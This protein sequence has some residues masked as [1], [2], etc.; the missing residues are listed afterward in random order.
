MS[1]KKKSKQRKV[2]T[3]DKRKDPKQNN[4][5]I[6]SQTV[7]KSIFLILTVVVISI[8]GIF[9]IVD[10]DWPTSSTQEIGYVPKR[11]PIPIIPNYAPN[12]VKFENFVGS[13][14]CASC[15]IDIYTKW[16]SST[17]AKAGGSPDEVKIIGKFDS[18]PRFFKDAVLTPYRNQNGDFMFNLKIQDLPEQIYKVDGVV[19]G[20]HMI[21]G[22][23]QTYFTRFPDGTMRM[24]PFDFIRDE[25][26][27]FGE[28]SE[29]RGW[30]PI[31]PDRIID[32][33]SESFPSRIL[34][35]HLNRQNCQECHG[36]QIQSEYALDKKMYTTRYTTLAINCESCHGPGKEHIQKVSIRKSVV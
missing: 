27:W 26:V 24:L 8:Y 22:G 19:G 15:H 2:V 28:T 6:L 13:D 16:K 9:R 11:K 1:N 23:T 20:G 18:I 21:A 7:V 12:T 34:G 10:F 32:K 17:H 29:G 35:T 3:I 31:T 25:N 36:S 4:S 30:I 14:A 5:K 33:A